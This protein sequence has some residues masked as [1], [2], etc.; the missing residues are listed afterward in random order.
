MQVSVCSRQCTDVQMCTSSTAHEQHKPGFSVYAEVFCPLGGGP[1]LS[2]CVTRFKKVDDREGAQSF[3]N[4][5]D[6]DIT[7]FCSLWDSISFRTEDEP[8]DKSWNVFEKLK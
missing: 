7:Q 4:A 6:N 2:E 1:S 3:N 8:M 5:N